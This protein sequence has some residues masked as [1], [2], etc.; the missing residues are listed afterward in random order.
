MQDLLCLALSLTPRNAPNQMRAQ[1]WHS[2]QSLSLCYLHT[3]CFC[4]N[5]ESFEIFFFKLEGGGGGGVT[6]ITTEEYNA[7]YSMF[8]SDC[9]PQKRKIYR[10]FKPVNEGEVWLCV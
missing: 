9:W 6:I 10:T 1:F 5:S 4:S 3:D 2:T 7:G 8:G